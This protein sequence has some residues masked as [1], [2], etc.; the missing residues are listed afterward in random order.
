[1]QKVQSH[2]HVWTLKI[3]R[4]CMAGVAQLL[5]VPSCNKKVVGS[6]PGQGM[7]LRCRIDAWSGHI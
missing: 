7:C 3:R 2:T 1:M 4:D 6:I 5:G